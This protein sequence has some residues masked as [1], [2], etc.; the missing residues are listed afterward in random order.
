[1]DELAITH[2]VPDKS[3]LDGLL[4]GLIGA[5]NRHADAIA[6]VDSSLT[7]ALKGGN[8]QQ[9]EAIVAMLRNLA[10][11]P[12]QLSLVKEELSII[13]GLVAGGGGDNGSV[14]TAV[15]NLDRKVDEF[16]ATQEQRL[17]AISAKIDEVLSDLATLK[18]NNPQ[19][20][21]EIAAIESKLS[22]AQP[23]GGGADTSGGTGEVNP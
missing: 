8:Q 12:A 13:H 10:G 21:D 1:M 18:E 5:I 9:F 16:M 22:L 2:K 7:E 20:E 15:N 19:I 17:Q 14:L 4:G 11:V 3:N 6:P 23:G